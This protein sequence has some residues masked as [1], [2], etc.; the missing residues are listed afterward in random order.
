M[1]FLGAQTSSLILCFGKPLKSF[2]Q[3][4]DLIIVKFNK[5]LW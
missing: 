3:G 2:K 4:P 5:L 1:L